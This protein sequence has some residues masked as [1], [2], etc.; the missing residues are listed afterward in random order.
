MKRNPNLVNLSKEHHDGLVV[1]LRVKKAIDK[2]D[3]AKPVLAYVLHQW[4]TLQHHFSQEE[5]NFLNQDN[6]NQNHPA[7]LQMLEEHQQFAQLIKKLTQGSNQLN[8]DLLA[9]AALLK[10]HI[11]F[12]ERVL[13]PYVEE[14]L[15]AEALLAIGKNLDLTHQMLDVDWGF[16]FWD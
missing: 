6:I 13:F 2:Q 7:I 4:P 8:Q 12:E 14:A 9:F 11:R 3:D 16:V 15:S 1:A 10:N 5:E